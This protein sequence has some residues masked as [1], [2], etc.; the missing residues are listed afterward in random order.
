MVNLCGTKGVHVSL[1]HMHLFH[2]LQQTLVDSVFN[3]GQMYRLKHE[4]YNS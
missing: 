3:D 4:F 2:F 1:P